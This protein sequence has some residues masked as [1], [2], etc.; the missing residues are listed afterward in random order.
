M[1][2]AAC[3]LLAAAFAVAGASGISAQP[4]EPEPESEA[5]IVRPVPPKLDDFEF[6]ENDDGVPDGWYNLRDAKI[7]KEGGVVGPKYL[8]FECTKMGRPARL[9]RAFGVDGR[10]VEALLLGLWVRIDQNPQRRATRRRPRPHHRLPRHQTAAPNARIARPVDAP[11]SRQRFG[12]GGGVVRRIPVPPGAHDAIM[13]VGLLG[14][15]GVLDIDGLTVELIPIGGTET[16]NLVSNPGFELG[17]PDPTGWVVENGARRGFPGYRS[18]AALELVRDGARSSIAL[19]LPIETFGALNLTLKAK[20]QGL[21]GSGGATASMFFLDEDG[22]QVGKGFPALNWSGT[23]N[24][25]RNEA[26]IIPVNPGA[27]YALLQFDKLDG[28]GKLFLDDVVVTAAPNVEAGRWTPYHIADITDDWPAFVP[29]QGVVAQSALD[30]SF[31]NR[32]PA[33]RSGR[34]V[35]RQG[36]LQFERADRARFFG[37]QLL[38]P[39]AFLEAE[40]ADA[41]ADRLARAGVN[42]RAPWRSRYAARPRP[43]PVR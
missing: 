19:A 9:S 21:R 8:K 3:C 36:R 23:F 34:V 35:V 28:V 11:K 43:Q 33:G 42:L 37:V 16:A 17:D 15:T 38:A 6:D 31:L 14:A 13:S 24:E 18:S 30:F 7:V 27:T 5:L 12:M 40:K 32:G 25:W 10:K 20:A 2:R 4:A 1:N 41:M 26:A 39:S 22:R 29:S